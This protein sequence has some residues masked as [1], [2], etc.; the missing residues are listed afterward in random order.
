MISRSVGFS[1][2]SVTR[3]IISMIFVITWKV[4]RSG[5]GRTWTV[6][7]LASHFVLLSS[8][9]SE[10]GCWYLGR[11]LRCSLI[12]RVGEDFLVVGGYFEDKRG[13]KL[14]AW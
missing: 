7:T 10:D 3:Q 1:G 5:L 9:E 8:L 4:K 6:G 14:V 12:P 11:L 13:L 2:G